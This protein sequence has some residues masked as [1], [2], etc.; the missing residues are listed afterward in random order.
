MQTPRFALPRRVTVLAI[1]R[2]A[3]GSV[4]ESIPHHV[5]NH[6]SGMKIV[7]FESVVSDVGVVKCPEVI[8]CCVQFTD[9]FENR[10]KRETDLNIDFS[11]ELVQK[12]NIYE[13]SE[14]I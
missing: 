1:E 14:S 9:L 7:L 8:F 4:Q 2:E 12:E 6:F 10:E 5:V 13:I 3:E 11:S